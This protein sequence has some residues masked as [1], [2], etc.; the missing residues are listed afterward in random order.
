VGG[1]TFLH[2]KLYYKATVIK[3]HGI[4]TKADTLIGGTERKTQTKIHYTYQHPIRE[5]EARNTPLVKLAGW[6][7]VCRRL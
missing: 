7:A 6:L 5:K 2:L 4:G 3:Q 1:I